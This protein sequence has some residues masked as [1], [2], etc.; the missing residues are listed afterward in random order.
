MSRPQV[1]FERFRAE[2]D[3]NNARFGALRRTLAGLHGQLLCKALRR[4]LRRSLKAKAHFLKPWGK[5]PAALL[6]SCGECSRP[7]QAE[8]FLN[9]R[10][11]PARRQ[12]QSLAAPRD[13]AL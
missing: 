11:R 9:L 10:I 3:S 6:W 12:A 1:Q 7:G 13:A 8:S 2:G 5:C 4:P